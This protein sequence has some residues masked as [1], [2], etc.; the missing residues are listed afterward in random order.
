MKSITP[1]EF[2]KE[3]SINSGISDL[4]VVRDIYYGVVR[5]ITR[6]LKG[7]H[8]IQLPDLGD[9]NL[10]IHKSRKFIDVFGKPGILPPKP[11]MK[12]K[13]NRNVKKYFHTLG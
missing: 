11:T 5:T 1:V 4:R 3:V 2:F 10:Q 12:F 6:E 13:A 8:T 9:F 7:R